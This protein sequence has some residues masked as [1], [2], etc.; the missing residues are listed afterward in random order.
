MS[1]LQA[2]HTGT[3]PWLLTASGGLVK[4]CRESPERLVSPERPAP[5]SG[6][7]SCRLPATRHLQVLYANC[8]HLHGRPVWTVLGVRVRYEMST[9]RR[10]PHMGVYQLTSVVRFTEVDVSPK[11]RISRFWSQWDNSRCDGDVCWSELLHPLTATFGAEPLA[12]SVRD[13]LLVTTLLAATALF[14]RHLW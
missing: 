11:K 14:T 10:S 2:S 7:A 12:A 9:W 1:I 4:R 8:G 5:D 3:V 13:V 6:W